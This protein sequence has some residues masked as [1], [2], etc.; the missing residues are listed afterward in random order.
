METNEKMKNLLEASKKI[1]DA[2]LDAL[3]TLRGAVYENDPKNTHDIDRGKA[4]H[5][6]V[7][8]IAYAQIVA[9]DGVRMQ[10]DMLYKELAE[11]IE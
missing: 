8:G 7:Y 3:E 10:T 6:L 4:S 11:L 1:V 2:A 9:L 5:E